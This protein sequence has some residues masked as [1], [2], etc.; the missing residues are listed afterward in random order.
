MRP[1]FEQHHYD[2]RPITKVGLNYITQYVTDFV[3]WHD[4]CL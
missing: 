3:R 2:Y 1:F 4:E